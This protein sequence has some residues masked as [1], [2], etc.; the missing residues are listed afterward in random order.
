MGYP[1]WCCDCI[2]KRVKR[3]IIFDK[4]EHDDEVTKVIED[5]RAY[6]SVCLVYELYKTA[7]L[8]LNSCHKPEREDE[9]CVGDQYGKFITN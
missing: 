2:F 7:V 6:A 4:A 5:I 1:C 8:V 3:L 9:N